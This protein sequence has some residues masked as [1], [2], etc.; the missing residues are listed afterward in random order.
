MHV[1]PGCGSLGHRAAAVQGPRVSA[2]EG[3][4]R[5]SLGLGTGSLS[6]RGGG[7]ALKAGALPLS[8]TPSHRNTGTVGTPYTEGEALERIIVPLLSLEL[9]S[10]GIQG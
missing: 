9:V 6:A 1:D 10:A 3:R 7:S 4:G 8:E 2:R 5:G